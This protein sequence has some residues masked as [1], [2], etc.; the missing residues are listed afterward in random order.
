MENEDHEADE[1]VFI[2]RW[3]KKDQ[4]WNSVCAPRWLQIYRD[5]HGYVDTL[6]NQTSRVHCQFRASHGW[7]VRL[8]GF[9]EMLTSNS[10]KYWIHA[11][12]Q[13]ETL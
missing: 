13:V 5:T 8:S 4:K 2:E 1:G 10:Y 3:S 12:D 11:N 9:M 6:R 7:R